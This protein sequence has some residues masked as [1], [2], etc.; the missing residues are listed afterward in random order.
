VA[1]ANLGIEDFRPWCE[2][3][4]VRSFSDTE[5]KVREEA[6][7]CFRHLEGLQ[8]ESFASLID[9]YCNSPAFEDNSH[10]LLYALEESVEKLPGVVCKVCEMFLKRFG[11]EAR[12]FRTGRAADGYT[13]T[14]LIFRV[15]HQH[16]RDQWGPRTLDVIDRLCQEGVG[17]VMAQ[18][19]EFDR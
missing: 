15:Y 13:V 9:V 19:Q 7:N 6:G 8:L 4:L 12:D 16:Q 10:S 14:K 5:K 17:E 11:R 2:K 18:L 3:Q 1:S